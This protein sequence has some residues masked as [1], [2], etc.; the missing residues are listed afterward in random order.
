MK[1]VVISRHA[2]LDAQQQAL[3]DLG[4]EVIETCDQ[5][6][7]ERDNKRWKEQEVEAIFTIAL[8]PNLLARLSEAFRV[9]TFDME[10]VGMAESEEQAE[11]WCAQ[12]PAT[13]S[14]LPAREGSL[15]LLE[16]RSVSEI[17]IEIQTKRV[18]EVKS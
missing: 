15:R 14:Y 1:S 12:S 5:Y 2:L 11:A 10:S 18:W 16:F 8:P 6:D 3:R 17:K 13:R 7:P 9:F 4:A